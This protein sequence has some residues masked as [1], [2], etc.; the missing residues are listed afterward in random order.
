LTVDP[1]LGTTVNRSTKILHSLQSPVGFSLRSSPLLFGH[2]CSPS[3]IDQR[4]VSETGVRPKL[5]KGGRKREGV[6]REPK[7][8]GGSFP[9]LIN[10]PLC[11]WSVPSLS[12]H[13]FRTHRGSWSWIRAA[14]VTIV[15]LIKRSRV[16]AVA[17]HDRPS[18]EYTFFG[19]NRKRKKLPDM[20]RDKKR[21]QRTR[22]ITTLTT[23]IS[24][25]M[26]LCFN[27]C[28]SQLEPK[29]PSGG[30]QKRAQRKTKRGREL[31]GLARSAQ[32][33]G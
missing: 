5:G 24:E 18:S 7:E 6:N 9:V 30:R 29:R 13:V 20:Q 12:P 21:V 27:A 19:K 2:P 4:F 17:T 3:R 10:L 15:F 23:P 8:R 14:A 1:H 11:P 16:A 22:T 32:Q 28:F 25:V 33:A 26:G 31:G